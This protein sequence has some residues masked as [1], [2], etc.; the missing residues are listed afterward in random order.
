MTLKTHEIFE[1]TLQKTHHW[2][3][4]IRRQMDWEDEQRA[5][6]ALRAVLHTLRD[7]LTVDEAVHLG[8]Q[9]PMLIRGLYYEGW[10]PADKPVKIRDVD[11]FA[12]V[13]ADYFVNYPDI[14]GKCICSAVFGVIGNR[15]S[16]GEVEDVVNMLP[17]EIQQL[18]PRKV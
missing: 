2:L 3:E 11:E 14:D 5:Y 1:S 16:E 4:D 15:I 17:K 6:V 12:G 13:V 8:A 10:T 7:R 18:W 9:L